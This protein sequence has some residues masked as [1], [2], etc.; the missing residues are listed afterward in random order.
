MKK[1]A[2]LL[3]LWA[4][5]VLAADTNELCGKEARSFGDGSGKDIISKD[6]EF[7]VRAS[8]TA[9]KRARGTLSGINVSGHG[10]IIMVDDPKSKIKGQNL[11]AGKYTDLDDLRALALDDKHREIVAL[12]GHGDVLFFSAVVTGNVAPLRILRNKELDGT[13]SIAVNPILEQILALNPNKSEVLVFSRKANID[14]PEGKK[15]LSVLKVF[16][17]VQG[18]FLI[19]DDLGEDLFVIAPGTGVVTVVDLKTNTVRDEVKFPKVTDVKEIAYVPSSK[20]LEITTQK[21]VLKVAIPVA[22]V[23]APAPN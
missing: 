21:K 17:G 10:S 9:H 8:A 11:I 16:R 23:S 14:A 12:N 6:C 15:H 20:E 19:V 4:L 1:L 2:V 22:K 3:S 7:H 13:V 18:E 5:P